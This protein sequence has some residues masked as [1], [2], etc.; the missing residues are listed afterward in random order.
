[1][2]INCSID[3]G[4]LGNDDYGY[5]ENFQGQRRNHR[6]PNRQTLHYYPEK[7]GGKPAA[8]VAARKELHLDLPGIWRRSRCAI[9]RRL[10][11]T[12]KRASI[13]LRKGAGVARPSAI[14]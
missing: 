1:L 13:I 14:S 7:F 12:T 6:R 3:K 10:C 11:G 8:S 5:G 9:T 4:L 2:P